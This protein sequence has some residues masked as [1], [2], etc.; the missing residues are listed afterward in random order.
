MSIDEEKTVGSPV[1]RRTTFTIPRS[2]TIQDDGPQQISLQRELTLRRQ[3]SISITS[4]PVVDSR[5]R[6]VG[7][8]RYVGQPSHITI[9][10]TGIVGLQCYCTLKFVDELDFS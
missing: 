10:V 3:N 9:S 5:S 4:P 2:I 8:F 1:A 7:E 6:I